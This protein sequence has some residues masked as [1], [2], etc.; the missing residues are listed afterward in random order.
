MDVILSGCKLRTR[1]FVPIHVKTEGSQFQL[2]MMRHPLFSLVVF[3]QIF[4]FRFN[5]F[6]DT[7]SDVCP[8]GTNVE[9]WAIGSPFVFL[10]NLRV[11]VR[12]R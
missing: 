11:F 3:G 8:V 2:G 9:W 4:Y 1:I 7:S 10:V 12:S 6:E 5:G